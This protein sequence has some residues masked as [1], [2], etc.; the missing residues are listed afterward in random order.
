[1]AIKA[2]IGNKSLLTSRNFNDQSKSIINYRG[3][4]T[5]LNIDAFDSTS[6]TISD[7]YLSGV[8]SVIY[9]QDAVISF[10]PDNLETLPYFL[11]F[12]DEPGVSP[13]E[14]IDTFNTDTGDVVASGSSSVYGY[15]AGGPVDAFDERLTPAGILFNKTNG[16]SRGGVRIDRV[17]DISRYAGM[18]FDLDIP[19]AFQPLVSSVTLIV[20]DNDGTSTSEYTFPVSSNA[21]NRYYLS[22][23]DATL[24][25]GTPEYQIAESIEVV[26]NT[27]L[28]SSVIEEATLSG[29]Y[30]MMASGYARNTDDKFKIFVSDD[31][32]AGIPIATFS[33]GAWVAE[34]S[35]DIPGLSESL[36]AHLAA[37][38]HLPSGLADAFHLSRTSS[39]DPLIP[40]GDAD[41]V[42]L[43]SN[44]LSRAAL[45]V[46]K[47]SSISH[48]RG[49]PALANNLVVYADSTSRGRA[50]LNMSGSEGYIN[51]STSTATKGLGFYYGS[52]IGTTVE[53]YEI[54]NS[55][56]NISSLMVDASLISTDISSNVTFDV[57]LGGSNVI[58]G[59]SLGVEYPV[60]EFFYPTTSLQGTV[61]K[62]TF[63]IPGAT[64]TEGY[65]SRT[66]PPI[67]GGGN[68]LALTGGG[69]SVLAFK[70]ATLSLPGDGSDTW[71]VKSSP[72]ETITLTHSDPGSSSYGMRLF[73]KSPLRGYKF[74]L[75]KDSWRISPSVGMSDGVTVSTEPNVYRSIT[76]DTM[77][78]IDD[79]LELAKTLTSPFGGVDGGSV[80]TV[81][82]GNII[83][84]INLETYKY[85]E[86]T[87]DWTVAAPASAVSLNSCGS[88]SPGS[89]EIIKFGGITGGLVS[90]ATLS[91]DSGLSTWTTLASLADPVTKPFFGVNGKGNSL[92]I[93]GEY[94][95]AGMHATGCQEYVRS[96][97]AKFYGFGVKVGFKKIAGDADHFG[98]WQDSN[99]PSFVQCTIDQAEASGFWT[100]DDGTMFGAIGT[101]WEF[102]G[103]W[104]PDGTPDFNEAT[105]D[106]RWQVGYW[107][108]DNG[109]ILTDEGLLDGPLWDEKYSHD[110]TWTEDEAADYNEASEEERKT[111]GYWTNDDYTI[112]TDDGNNE[113]YP[114]WSKE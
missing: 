30:G 100:D 47:H 5:P 71:S 103:I 89:N 24:E 11:M 86:V 58:T 69:A 43:D 76:P 80:G 107:T 12:E 95:L 15:V 37:D 87:Q 40:A 7:A 51:A 67:S 111:N 8:Y 33:D 84:T 97:H 38:V 114:T 31:E 81:N 63:H 104:A 90:D 32:H 72:P 94:D 41:T 27:T 35:I 102:F 68:A 28:P 42:V 14:A 59:A 65:I 99:Y 23:N 112:P 61:L 108:D 70:D 83:A 22:F 9:I 79:V 66:S 4:I 1:M 64:S 91:L 34:R 73:S 6:I 29:V 113:W 36:R 105:F 26:I 53:T 110:G 2:K 98:Y 74:S 77:V 75:E 85:N 46:A 50:K 88:T 52:T 45:I 109:Q 18:M 62:L 20:T 44:P 25:T 3:L 96:S 10:L 106:E 60:E 56:F 101:F 13:R 54:L 39:V 57:N 49:N 55:P 82:N 17:T 19:S 48:S 21:F 92:V 78:E 16:T 93:A